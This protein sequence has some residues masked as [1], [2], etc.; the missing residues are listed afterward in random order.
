M[1]TSMN[2]ETWLAE[3]PTKKGTKFELNIWNVRRIE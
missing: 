1:M 2:E 3:L